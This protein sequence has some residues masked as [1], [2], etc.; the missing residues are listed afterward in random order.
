MKKVGPHP[1]PAL[2]LA[3]SAVAAMVLA[4]RRLLIDGL[5][6]VDGNV[7]CVT[8]PNWRLA[9]GLWLDGYLP[10]WNPLRNMGTP[11]LGDPITMALYPVQW[12]LSALP[13]YA[14][15]TRSWVVVHTL[16]AA[17]FWAALA[18]RW[19]VEPGLQVPGKSF[20][21]RPAEVAASLA[22]CFNAYIMVRVVFPHCFAAAAWVPAVLYF[23]ETGSA[24]ALAAAFALQWLAGYPS[25]CVLTVLLSLGLA[26]LK[27]RQ[28][29][30][31]LAR[32]G[33]ISLGLCA[34]QL[35]PFVEFLTRSSRGVRLDPSFAAQFSIPVPQLLKSLL[36]PQWYQLSPSMTGDPAMVCFYFGLAGIGLAAWGAWK[37]GGR[38]RLLAV[39]AS[40]CLLLS[41]GSHLPGYRHLV[42]LHFFRFPN[43]WLLPASACLTLLAAAGASRIRRPSWAWACVAVLCVDLLVFA[44]A[45]KS[46]WARPEFL[47]EAP[48]L[49]SRAMALAPGTRIMHTEPLLQRWSQGMLETEE[50]Y[51]LMRD[52]LAP[53]YGM[54]FG[55]EE[56]SNLQTLRL[57]A[58]QRYSR[59]LAEASAPQEL[60]DWAG[61]GLIIGIEEGEGKVSRDSIRVTANPT[62]RQRLFLPDPSLGKVSVLGCKPGHAT[63]HATLSRPADLVFSETHHPGWTAAIDGK[64]APLG[65]W[66]DTFMS[67]EVPAGSHEV[68]FDYDPSSFWVG[69]AATAATL[70]LLAWTAL[71]RR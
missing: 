47:T 8:F 32:A 22:G 17:V 64:K 51:L 53:S 35:L 29:L 60:A 37:G 67:V 69:L 38:E 15:F 25:F 16:I 10:L 12:L 71:R 68:I 42:F 41:L 21:I 28:G 18:R 33:A 70:L 48:A 13:D 62:P 46:A 30:M 56:A 59:R 39:M 40:A 66:Q 27:G 65:K 23:Q 50:D 61:I 11:Y 44:Q 14:S 5:V 3:L 4:W 49:A 7:L 6:P 2:A 52:F 58:A 45:P 55:I 57:A 43:N 63:A 54:A 36:L 31:L 19:Y 9:R 1:V 26:L 34:I 24:P 20:L